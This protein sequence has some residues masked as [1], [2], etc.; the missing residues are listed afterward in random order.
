MH[1]TISLDR[2]ALT[3][4]SHEDWPLALE[5]AQEMVEV[6]GGEASAQLAIAGAVLG[7]G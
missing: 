2:G 4:Q 5:F 1:K 7:V 3:K 6:A